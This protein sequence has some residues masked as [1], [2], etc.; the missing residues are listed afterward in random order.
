MRF[1][2]WPI[3]IRLAAAGAMLAAAGLI[4]DALRRFG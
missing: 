1:A 4:A 3:V 2:T